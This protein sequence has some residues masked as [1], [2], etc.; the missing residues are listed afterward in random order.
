MNTQSVLEVDEILQPTAEEAS[1]TAA[2]P[3]PHADMSPGAIKAAIVTLSLAA[4][5]LA[6]SCVWLWSAMYRYQNCL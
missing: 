3:N 5:Y 4:L 2:A 1:S 6:I